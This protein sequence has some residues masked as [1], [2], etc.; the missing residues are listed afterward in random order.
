MS[1]WHIARVRQRGLMD[2]WHLCGNYMKAHS[3][4]LRVADHCLLN[5]ATEAV[6]GIVRQLVFVAPH[7]SS[8]FISSLFISLDILCLLCVWIPFAILCTK[9][10]SIWAHIVKDKCHAPPTLQPIAT[11][12]QARRAVKQLME[13]VIFDSLMNMHEVFLSASRG[14]IPLFWIPLPSIAVFMMF[15]RGERP[16]TPLCWVALNE[17]KKRGRKSCLVLPLMSKSMH[18]SLKRW[19]REKET[20]AIGTPR[21]RPKHSHRGSYHMQWIGAFF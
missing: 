11:F 15:S 7:I 17:E 1:D 8:I 4:R 5:K 13:S 21:T 6:S 9:L 3:V 14:P 20:E 12:R 2:K 16:A 18:L 19:E 10:K